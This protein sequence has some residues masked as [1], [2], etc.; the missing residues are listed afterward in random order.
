VYLGESGSRL[1]KVVADSAVRQIAAGPGPFG[2]RVVALTADGSIVP[3]A[4]DGT[5]AGDVIV[6]EGPVKALRLFA[7]GVAYQVG[8]VV[9]IVGPGAT[10]VPLPGGATMV[11]V[12]AGRVLFTSSGDLGAVTIATGAVVQLVDGSPAKPVQGQLDA[13]GLAWARGSTVSWRPG[14]LPAA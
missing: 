10:T 9:E 14:P 3:L 2:I 7:G 12:A 13:A 11:D 8:S 6:P 1:F 4:A 5:A